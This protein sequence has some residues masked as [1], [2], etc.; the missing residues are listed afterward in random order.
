M[1]FV[2]MV[3]AITMA[4]PIPGSAGAYQEQLEQL[5]REK[6]ANEKFYQALDKEYNSLNHWS[7]TVGAQARYYESEFQRLKDENAVLQERIS[8]L[9]QQA[10]QQQAVAQA[11]PPAPAPEA[12]LVPRTFYYPDYYYGGCIMYSGLYP[13]GWGYPGW[14]PY[15]PYGWPVIG[16]VRTSF[17][18]NTVVINNVQALSSRINHNDFDRHVRGNFDASRANVGMTQPRQQFQSQRGSMPTVSQR[19]FQQRFSPVARPG[20]PQK[21][22]RGTMSGTRLQMTQPAYR[23]VLPAARPQIYSGATQGGWHH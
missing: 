4:T 23:P 16:R 7:R 10:Q 22:A 18:N 17:A 19:Q 20:S 8:Q 2:A 9:E 12:Q 5:R 15:A 1:L 11:V 6:A 21:F 14:Y 3:L 13:P